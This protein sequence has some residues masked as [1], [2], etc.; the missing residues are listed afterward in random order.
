MY[1]DQHKLCHLTNT[2]WHFWHNNF[3]FDQF[4]VLNVLTMGAAGLVKKW[5]CNRIG[6]HLA[7]AKLEFN[8]GMKML[9]TAMLF[10]F[11]NTTLPEVAQGWRWHPLSLMKKFNYTTPYLR[12]LWKFNQKWMSLWL[13]LNFVNKKPVASPRSLMIHLIFYILIRVHEVEW[14]LM[15]W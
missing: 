13:S 9:S 1:H 11:H 14:Y 8:L 10:S 3:T 7:L 15:F 5:T 12:R 6:T 4:A 2:L